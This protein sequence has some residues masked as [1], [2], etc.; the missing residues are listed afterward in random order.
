MENL[1]NFILSFLHSSAFSISFYSSIASDL[2]ISTLFGVVIAF[3][4]NKKIN[5]LDHKEQKIEEEIERTRKAIEL[6][7]ILKNY[8][9]ELRPKIKEWITDFVLSAEVNEL[10]KPIEIGSIPRFDISFWYVYRDG[11][12]MSKLLS[13]SLIKQLCKFFEN[14]SDARRSLDWAYEGWGYITIKTIGKMSNKFLSVPHSFD[15]RVIDKEKLK[16]YSA[17]ILENLTN[18]NSSYDEMEKAIDGELSKLEQE[19]SNLSKY[20]SKE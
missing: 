12:E 1:V 13:P 2:I 11:G 6:I 18:A 10:Y 9:E 16:F 3:I 20:G 5:Q 7:T 15:E 14:L 19:L 4:V 17:L 8:A